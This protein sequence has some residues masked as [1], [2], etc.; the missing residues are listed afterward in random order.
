MPTANP[1]AAERWLTVEAVTKKDTAWA[2]AGHPVA[3][4]QYSVGGSQVTGVVSPAPAA[5]TATTQTDDEV[6]VSGTGFRY[7]FNKKTGTLSSMKARGVELLKNGPALD[8]WRAPISNE[9]EGEADE[10]R[11]VGLDRLATTVSDVSVTTAGTGVAAT[12][13]IAVRSTVAAP[14]VTNASFKQSMTYTITGTGEVRLSHRVDPQG[15]VRDLIYLPRV[16]VTLGVPSGMQRFTYYGRGPMEN[17][18]DRKD[19][20]HVGV[21]S[22]TVDSEYVPYHSPQHYGNHE[23]VR[24]ATLTDG[25]TGGLL[26]AGDLDVSVT[27]Y[28]DMD[29]AAYPFALKR[30]DG[31]NTLH[32]DH[33]VSGVSETFHPTMPK[34]RVHGN[35]EYAYTVLL[36]PLSEAEVQAGGQPAG[37]VACT[38]EAVL[39]AADQHVDEGASVKALLSITNPCKGPLK[40]VTAT[41]AGSEGWST[42][43]ASLDIGAVP[44]GESVS[45]EVTVRRAVDSAAGVR[46]LTAEVSAN[47]QRNVQVFDSASVTLYG[48]PRS[49]RGDVPVSDLP[50]LSAQN[51]WGPVE[52]DQANG[53]NV[54][55]DGS[56]IRIGDQTYDKGLGVHATSVVEIYLGGACSSFTADVGIDEEAS[57]GSVVFEVYAD[58][59]HKWASPRVTNADPAVKA[60]VDVTG[61]RVLKLRV[62]D[63][64][65]GNAWDHGD[66]A[67]ATVH[68]K[69]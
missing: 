45:R 30:N 19:G 64:G 8:A 13:T 60:N 25:A 12:T 5:A 57:G 52:R 31:W 4:A 67:A 47:A 2:D 42:D 50:F 59:V 21:Y 37:P 6:V 23:D 36:R 1:T 68:C 28:E 51:G 10:W 17:Y 40:N 29:R 43:P 34:Y 16:G 49:P 15:K 11:P 33:A 22:S 66:W 53:E 9:M 39:T 20:S 62:A 58:G 7:V 38:P 32:L 24:W 18:N 61:A 55:G 46:R 14:G 26:V 35:S 69:A 48:N 27:P 44:A 41:L 3:S 63:G 65:D 56:P 54:G